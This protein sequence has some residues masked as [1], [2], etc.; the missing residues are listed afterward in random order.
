[1]FKFIEHNGAARL[2]P[3]KYLPM[4]SVGNTTLNNILTYKE[5]DAAPRE[6][7]AAGPPDKK[8]PVVDLP[9]QLKALL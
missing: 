3:V 7:A 1:M 2:K 5:S 8:E 4:Y 6:V 9:A